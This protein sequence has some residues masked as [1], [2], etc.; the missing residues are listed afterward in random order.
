[1]DDVSSANMR[2]QKNVGVLLLA[3]SAVGAHQR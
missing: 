3:G 1:M 2:T